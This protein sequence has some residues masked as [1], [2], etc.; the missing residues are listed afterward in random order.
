MDNLYKVILFS[1]YRDVYSLNYLSTVFR[2]ICN[3]IDVEFIKTLFIETKTKLDEKNIFGKNKYKIFYTYGVHVKTNNYK[4][5]IELRAIVNFYLFTMQ[6]E[7]IDDIEKFD[8]TIYHERHSNYISLI[9][10]KNE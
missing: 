6:C 3:I 8:I 1:C 2:K 7:D 9:E 4:K 10:N 5:L